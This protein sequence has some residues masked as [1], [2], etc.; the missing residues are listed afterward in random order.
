MLYLLRSSLLYLIG[1]GICFATELSFRF[2]KII[3]SA[4]AANTIDAHVSCGLY[5]FNLYEILILQKMVRI[6]AHTSHIN[7]TAV[8]VEVSLEEDFRCFVN[9][10]KQNELVVVPHVTCMHKMN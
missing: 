5:M 4:A 2:C 6:V 3:K 10:K 9:M 8:P 7:C 1:I